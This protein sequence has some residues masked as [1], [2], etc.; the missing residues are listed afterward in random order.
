MTNKTKPK[1]S[2]HRVIQDR[3][4]PYAFSKQDI[5]SD[6]LRSMFEAARWAPS[7]RNEQPWRFIIS[8]RESLEFELL[9]GSLTEKNREWAQF[10]PY[11]VLVMA[12]TIFKRNNK[13][14]PHAFYDTGMAVEN[15]V[16][17]ATELGIFAHQM[18]GF[19]RQKTISDFDIP[20]GTEPIVIIAFGYRAKSG[21][22]PK[23]LYEKEK[24]IRTRNEYDS[25][26]FGKKFGIKT[27]F[28]TR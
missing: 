23:D 9:L 4:S 16:L 22:A 11:L 8:N 24:M 5:L 21:D 25:F 15:L 20:N 10:A 18:G 1:Y 19:D 2:M 14:N 7:S 3:W 27:K 6:H 26:I 17:Q 13:P 12:N 28:F